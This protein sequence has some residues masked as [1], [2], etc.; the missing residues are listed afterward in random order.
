MFA[1]IAISN[2]AYCVIIPNRTEAELLDRRTKIR[3]ISIVERRKTDDTEVDLLAPV[4]LPPPP[5]ISD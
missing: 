4:S 3:R 5:F 2:F 1:K